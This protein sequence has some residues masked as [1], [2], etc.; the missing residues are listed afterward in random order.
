M[1]APQIFGSQQREMQATIISRRTCR[2]KAVSKPLANLC[3]YVPR[4]GRGRMATL[5][6]RHPSI[7]R[8]VR[9]TAISSAFSGELKQEASSVSEAMVTLAITFTIMYGN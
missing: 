9:E 1:V 6:I 2:R 8:Q 4:I 3:D 7:E 5:A